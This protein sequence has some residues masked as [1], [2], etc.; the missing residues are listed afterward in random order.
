MKTNN[1]EKVKEMIAHNEYASYEPSKMTR[2]DDLD[3]LEAIQG[4]YWY[5]PEKRVWFIHHPDISSVVGTSLL[6]ALEKA[7]KEINNLEVT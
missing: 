7:L 1:F 2:Y 3:L 4:N 5:S 6:D